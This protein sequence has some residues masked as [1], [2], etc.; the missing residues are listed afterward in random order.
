MLHG[1]VVNLTDVLS[2]SD[3]EE[4]YEVEQ[5]D[6]SQAMEFIDKIQVYDDLMKDHDQVVQ[7]IQDMLRV[8]STGDEK[9]DMKAIDEMAEEILTRVGNIQ[10]TDENVPKPTKQA[11]KNYLIKLRE[12]YINSG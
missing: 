4:P 10:V 11:I 6:L 2:D 3:W 9:K 5:V 12:D 7:Y 8:I 1:H